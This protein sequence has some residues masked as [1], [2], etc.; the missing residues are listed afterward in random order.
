[1]NDPFTSAFS[2]IGDNIKKITTGENPLF[3]PQVSNLFGFNIPGV[4]IVSARDYFLTQMESWFTSIPLTTQWILLIE[5][6]PKCI[7]TAVMQNLER[8]GGSKKAFN[9]DQAVKIL[10]SYPLQK[11]TGCL[12]AQ[13]VS[14]P[15]D[16]FGVESINIENNRGFTPAPIANGRSYPDVLTID[17]LETNTS[18]VDFLI[19]P[20][21]IAGS[22]YGFVARNSKDPKEKIKNV[23]TNITLLQYTRTFQKISM[24]PRKIWTFHNC[25]PFSVPDESAGYDSEA[26]TQ[27]RNFFQT[28]WSFSHYSVENNMYLPLTSI[29]NR[30]SK[31]QL[32]GISALRKSGDPKLN[33]AGFF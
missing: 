20:W 18:F 30:I 32:P 1:M 3:A 28:K 15:G 19:R 10:K 31:G 24:I 22:H 23:K 9:I 25:A 8:I 2:S 7:N 5:E 33:V 16:S 26:F 12:F 13:G 4:P 11:I 29:I 17:F 21:V 27:G 6:F 14:F